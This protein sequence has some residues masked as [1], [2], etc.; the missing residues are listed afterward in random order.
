MVRGDYSNISGRLIRCKRLP[1]QLR[2]P[3]GLSAASDAVDG[4][5]S[6]DDQLGAS[7]VFGLVRP[8]AE[9]IERLQRINLPEISL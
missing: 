7:D 1:Q 2:R 9:L 8:E 4:E 3:V 6:V 5:P